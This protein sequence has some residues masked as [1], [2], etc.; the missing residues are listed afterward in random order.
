[1][2]ELQIVILAVAGSSPVGHPCWQ[3]PSPHL[4]GKRGTRGAKYSVVINPTL[5]STSSP[6][7][8]VVAFWQRIF[9]DGALQECG[10]LE[11]LVTACE[12]IAAVDDLDLLAA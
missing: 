3:A 6:E 7:N 12:L 11:K 8:T 5:R 4:A 10:D 2:V 1:M 9:N